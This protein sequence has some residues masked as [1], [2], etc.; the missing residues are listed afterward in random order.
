VPRTTDFLIVGGGIV[1]ITV[2]L[3]LRRRFPDQSV[4]LLEKEPRHA[5]FYYSADSLKARFT[6]EGNRAMTAYCLERGLRINQCGKLVVAR[7]PDELPALD[8][9]L[10]RAQANGVELNS[11]PATDARAIEPRVKTFERALYSPTTA[12][13]D[14][15]EIVGALATDARTAGVSLCT[16][17]AYIGC[18]A[19]T[20]RTTAGA[21]SAGYVV[22]AAGLYADRVARDFGFSERYRILP[23][24]GL[25]L[26][27]EAPA[28]AFR[29]NIY[30]VPN[31]EQPFLGVHITVT[32]D[33]RSKL[34]PTALPALW[35]EHYGLQRGF[36]LDEFLEIVSREAGLF[37]RNDFGFRRLA[38]QELRKARRTYLVQLA[39]ELASDV[40]HSHILN[41]VSPAFTC[42]FPFA[43]HVVDEIAALSEARSS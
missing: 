4:T 6:R 36:K 31:L 38:S 27:A 13:V 14:P 12:S 7:G 1:G 23:F 10:R 41:A 34:G 35:R 17:T 9:L 30:P 11:I 28:P 24:K 16:G 8:V 37:A 33:G 2:A 20:V 21:I 25:Y 42:A 29:T 19:S 18:A 3:A 26:G 39:A 15:T 22:N 32:V 5:G 43:A 40:H